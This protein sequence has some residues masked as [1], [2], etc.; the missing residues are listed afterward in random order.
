MLLSRNAIGVT[1]VVVRVTVRA[2]APSGPTRVTASSR[3]L[4][5][6]SIMVKILQGVPI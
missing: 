3:S 1:V 6:G 5:S 2:P 4:T